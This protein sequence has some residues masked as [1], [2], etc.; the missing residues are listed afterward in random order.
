MSNIGLV[1][2]FDFIRQAGRSGTNSPRRLNGILKRALIQGN[3]PGRLS[4][5]QHEGIG[6]LLPSILHRRVHGKLL[7]KS[8]KNTP[9]P[10]TRSEGLFSESI[11]YA[12]Q[13]N[14]FQI[15][16]SHQEMVPAWKQVTDSRDPWRIRSRPQSEKFWELFKQ[17][18]LCCSFPF[19]VKLPASLTK[20]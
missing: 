16:K 9:V 11:R 20:A 6:C 18:H 3:S 2:V 7:L 12:H 1:L 13:N 15:L 19:G 10:V 8:Q 5:T 4:P 17:V 14:D